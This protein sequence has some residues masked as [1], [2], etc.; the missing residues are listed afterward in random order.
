MPGSI[1]SLKRRPTA[2]SAAKRI[3]RMFKRTNSDDPEATSPADSG[4]S[5]DSFDS[6]RVSTSSRFSTSSRMTT[7][8][9]VEQPRPSVSRYDTAPSK[10]RE[11]VPPH[12]FFSSSS[13]PL[14][15]HGKPVGPGM[16]VQ[17]EVVIEPGTLPSPVD[18]ESRDEPKLSHTRLEQKPEPV[19]KSKNIGKTE[20]ALQAVS[21]PKPAPRPL[22][23]APTKK[24]I[25]PEPESPILPRTFREEPKVTPQLMP[26]F[27]VKMT[28]KPEPKVEPK[29]KSEP[30]EKMV[31]PPPTVEDEPEPIVKPSK[32][33]KE[34]IKPKP[35]A[36]VKHSPPKVDH[37]NVSKA[38]HKEVQPKMEPKVQPKTQIHKKSTPV[39]PPHIPEVTQKRSKAP[40]PEIPATSWAS[41]VPTMPSVTTTSSAPRAVSI[42]NMAPVPAY[43]VT[44]STSTIF[45][46]KTAPAPYTARAPTTAPA[47]MI[48]TAP[49]VVMSMLGWTLPKPAPIPKRAHSP[50]TSWIVASA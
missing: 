34:Q 22:P 23:E 48:A 20:E 3:G 1:K 27:E 9:N 11:V 26:K 46:P 38:Q 4:F 12:P 2:K 37:Q 5:K 32:P 47:P 18:K 21:T 36:E 45:V 44:L 40:S 6:S 28:Q 10:E 15:E 41:T 24:T 49:K 17:T 29:P 39:Q 8:E 30:A 16:P 35:K 13:E 19:E 43:S 50:A 42:P 33:I 25:L 14:L 7:K 31:V